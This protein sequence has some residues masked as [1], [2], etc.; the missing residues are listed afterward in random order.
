MNS[1][2]EAHEQNRVK[3]CGVCFRKPKP[4]MF[5]KISPFILN[6]IWK[7]SFN[8][9]SLEDTSL[10]VIICLSCTQTLKV[11]DSGKVDRKLPAVDYNELVK[12]QTVSTRSTVSEKCC[13]TICVVARMNGLE[14]KQY[15]KTSREQA[16]RPREKEEEIIMTVK[17]CSHCHSE[18]GPGKPHDCTR[19][20]TQE[21]LLDL[22][23]NHSEK[24]QQQVTSKMLDAM[25]E[26]QGVSMQG[27]STMLATKGLPK[28]VTIGNSRTLKSTP[29]YSIEDLS[30]LQISRNFS[31]NDTKAVA[32]FLRI[33]GGR[34]AVEPNLSQGLIERNHKLD[35]MFYLKEMTMKQKPK[36]KKNKKAVCSCD[37]DSDCEELEDEVELVEGMRDIQRPGIFVKDLDEFTAF[38]VNERSLDPDS[39][40]VQFGFDDGQG[41]LKVMEIV[42]NLEPE[43]EMDK[44]RS[45]YADG[46]CTRT[47]KLSSVKK[48]FVVGLVPQVQELYPNVRLMMEELK[49]DGIEYGLCADIKIYLCIIG[50]QTA[51]CMNPCPYCE[52]KAPWDKQYKVL[53]IG[54][55]NEW[56]RKYVENGSNKKKAK[57]YQNV[58]NP[59]LLTGK[60]STK[61]IEVLNISE[62]HCMTGV[63]GKLVSE[64]ERCAFEEK[65]TGEK[66]MNDFL[67]R[68]DISKCVYQGSNSFEGNQARKLLQRVDQLERDVQKLDFETAAKALP[69]VQ[70]LRELDKV[71]TSCFGQHLDP[72]YEEK[73]SRFSKQYRTLNISVTPKVHVIE[74]HVPEFLKLKGEETG[75]GFWSEQAME[76][77]H[78]DF[79]L[80]WEKVKVS[81]NHEEYGERLLSTVVR[82]AGKHL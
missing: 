76:S 77:G 2:S 14:Y 56:H 80:E 46:V 74:K 23:R 54:S 57:N 42:K 18:V 67:K 19:T 7:H 4:K 32:S 49:L 65:E 55:L 33:K 17:K 48:M 15:E 51:S 58:V 3:V 22:I 10:P 16:G 34:Q 31:D 64:M 35:S 27:G 5:Q 29:K 6:L 40:I 81:P 41:M 73:I 36:K 60:D 28:L 13:C 12:P 21:N 63:V 75:L 8:D 39:H 20:V 72:A 43:Q 53:S 1:K 25:C 47:S 44:K 66:F 61:T 38:L 26:E 82:Y 52:G 70:T 50:K 24:T 78:H 68:E 69:F 37:S 79:K 9:Y 11:I 62:L 71:V 45:K 59:P 30:K